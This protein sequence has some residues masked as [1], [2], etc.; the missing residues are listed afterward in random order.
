ML[1]KPL[2]DDLSPRRSLSDPLIRTD[3][4]L[5]RAAADALRNSQ[6]WERCGSLIVGSHSSVCHLSQEYA[7]FIQARKKVFWTCPVI[8]GGFMLHHQHLSYNG[9]ICCEIPRS[10]RSGFLFDDREI[11]SLP[12]ENSHLRTIMNFRN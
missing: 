3:L 7:C 8:I 1:P 5:L 4:R 6:S 11:H 2:A 10:P 9:R 12:I